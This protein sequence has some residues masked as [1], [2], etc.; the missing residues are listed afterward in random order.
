MV[1]AIVTLRGQFIYL[2]YHLHVENSKLR[3][4]LFSK[5]VFIFKLADSIP[6]ILLGNLAQ[7][8]KEALELDIGAYSEKIEL[9]LIFDE[10]F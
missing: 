4:H 7:V 10:V 3:H 8:A 2:S 5:V 1:F 9:V 6:V